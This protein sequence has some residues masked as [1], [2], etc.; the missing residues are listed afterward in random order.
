MKYGHVKKKTFIAEIVR[1]A[2]NAILKD[3]LLQETPLRSKKALNEMEKSRLLGRPARRCL[4]ER[5][6]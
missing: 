6:C 2:L 5:G 4:D 1:A 3:P